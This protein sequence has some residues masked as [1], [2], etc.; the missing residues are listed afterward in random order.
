MFHHNR[1]RT[2]PITSTAPRRPSR[3]T[4]PST[5]PIDTNLFPHIHTCDHRTP[6]LPR[7]HLR[8]GPLMRYTA[9]DIAV[10]LYRQWKR[11]LILIMSVGIDVGRRCGFVGVCER[12]GGAQE[13][14]WAC[15]L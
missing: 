2:N 14:Y 13:D 6:H 9:Y 1:L 4:L 3:F 8:G 7:R 10:A 5:I 12:D 11:I 15:E